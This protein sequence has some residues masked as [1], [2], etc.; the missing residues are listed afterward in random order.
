MSKLIIGALLVC[1]A[2]ALAVAQD[3]F[4]VKTGKMFTLTLESNPST[5]YSWEI[6]QPLDE[7][8]VA[9]VESI[10]NA[11]KT[12]R[13]GAAGVELWVFKAVGTGETTISMKYVRPWEKDTAPAEA[14]TFAVTIK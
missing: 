2:V 3:H 5:G 13:V 9:L 6:A 11:P 4:E 14:A 7:T 1:F 10:Y 8:K 12:D